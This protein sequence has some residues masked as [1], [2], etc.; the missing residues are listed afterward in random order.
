MQRIKALDVSAT[1]ADSKV[2]LDA[3]QKKLGVVPNLFKTFAHSPAVLKF[4]LSQGEA[5]ATGVLPAALREQIAI[6]T[7][8]ANQCDYC[9]S[10]H[11]LLGKGA[12]VDA[13]EATAN[14]KGHSSNAKTQAALTFAKAIVEHRGRLTTNQLQ[15]IRAAGFSEAEIVEIIAHV[16]MNIFTNYFNHIAETVVDF[17]LVSTADAKA[18]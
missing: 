1:P 15:A 4:Y 18:A 9:A 3:V 12:G 13:T 8:G 10:A 7:A 16:S 11:T 17:P 5:L 2:L 6:V 14:L